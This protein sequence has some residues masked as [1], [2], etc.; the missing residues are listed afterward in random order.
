MAD[1]PHE[2]YE[3]GV[4]AKPWGSEALFAAVEG[5]YVGKII[6]IR[7]GQA[8]S[9]QRHRE[10][11]ETITVLSGELLAEVGPSVDA[12]RRHPLPPGRCLHVPAGRLHRFSASPTRPSSRSR[13]PLPVGPP[14]SSGSRT[15]T[16][17]P[18][19]SRTEP[20]SNGPPGS[21]GARREPARA[22]GV[23]RR[24]GRCLFGGSAPG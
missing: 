15:A 24:Q 5:G 11:T 20:G 13:P 14:T 22:Q 2:P 23:P 3:P 4:T 7:A 1:E 10:K 6:S 8:V 18:T 17:A 9:L 21:S 12:L 19:P 16:A